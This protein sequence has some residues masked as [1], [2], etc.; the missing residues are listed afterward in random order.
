MLTIRIVTVTPAE[1]PNDSAGV[2]WTREECYGYF[3]HMLEKQDS[4]GGCHTD[5]GFGV[6]KIVAGG[7]SVLKNTVFEVTIVQA[8]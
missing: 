7:D 6:G 4:E 2:S 5:K 1:Q 3:A 8:E